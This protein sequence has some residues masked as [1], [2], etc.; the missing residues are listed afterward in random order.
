M[1]HSYPPA[2]RGCWQTAGLNYSDRFSFL[3]CSLKVYIQVWTLRFGKQVVFFCISV[4]AALPTGSIVVEY[5]Q[6]YFINHQQ[7]KFS[8]PASTHT[9][10][11]KET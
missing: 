7:E 10:L 6:E 4:S 2:P 3:L 8:Y 9:T 5:S 11:G 1:T